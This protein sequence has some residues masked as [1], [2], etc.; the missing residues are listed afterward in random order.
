MFIVLGLNGDAI[1]I[2]A[3]VAGI[4]QQIDQNLNQVLAIADDPVLRIAQV[5]INDLGTLTV[6]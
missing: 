1:T 3:G 5:N 4:A 6:E 2:P